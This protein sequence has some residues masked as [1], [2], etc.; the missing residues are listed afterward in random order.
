MIL[1]IFGLDFLRKNLTFKGKRNCL[2]RFFLSE[3]QRDL[4][5]NRIA[6]DN[7][8]GRKINGRARRGRRGIAAINR[9]T[10]HCRADCLCI[11]IFGFLLA[12]LHRRHTI[13]R[14]ARKHRRSRQHACGEREKQEKRC[15]PIFHLQFHYMR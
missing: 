8:D 6:D 2:N 3:Q 10:K 4:F 5:E 11:A 7:G 1:D 9:A 12:A 13:F 15:Q 14:I